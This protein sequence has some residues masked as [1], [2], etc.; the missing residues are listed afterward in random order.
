MYIIQY[1][2]FFLITSFSVII[3]RF[4]CVTYFDNVGVVIFE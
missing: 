1:V 3:L 4:I 2:L